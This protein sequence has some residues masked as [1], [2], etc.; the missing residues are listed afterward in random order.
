M[1]VA[2]FRSPDRAERVILGM[3]LAGSFL[4]DLG[5]FCGRGATLRC[6]NPLQS[7]NKFTQGH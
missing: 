4:V 3:I 7:P 6:R 1:D 2:A 5:H